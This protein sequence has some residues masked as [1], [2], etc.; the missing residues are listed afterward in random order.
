MHIWLEA[1]MTQVH[2][3][4]SKQ[5]TLVDQCDALVSDLTEARDYAELVIRSLIATPGPEDWRSWVLH[6]SDDLGDWI[7]VV[8]F[9]SLLGKP[10]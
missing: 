2:F 4:Y 5:G 8:P 10:H 9:A 7:L 3:H 1:R 6:V